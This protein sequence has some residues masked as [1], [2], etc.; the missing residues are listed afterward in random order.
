MRTLLL[1][2]FMVTLS[3]TAHA[4]RPTNMTLVCVQDCKYMSPAQGADGKWTVVAKNVQTFTYHVVQ[5]RN[6][7]I[8]FYGKPSP[9]ISEIS[10]VR[11]ATLDFG[12]LRS[13]YFKD[14]VSGSAP[15]SS[16]YI[17][18]EIGS[19]SEYGEFSLKS[20]EGDCSMKLRSDLGSRHYQIDC[21]NGTTGE[22]ELSGI[23]VR[24]QRDAPIF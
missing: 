1:T 22:F 19:Y 15:G 21:K 23:L 9:E 12:K 4:N 14:R 18:S 2:A 10:V 16:V 6:S 3:T 8:V 5:G 7:K 20:P 17:G 13:T 24:T 11:E